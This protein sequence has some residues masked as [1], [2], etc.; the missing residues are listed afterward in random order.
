LLLDPNNGAGEYSEDG[1]A[2][3]LPLFDCPTAIFVLDRQL[4][5]STKMFDPRNYGN[6]VMARHRVA[7]IVLANPK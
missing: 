7:E 2:P 1:H 6:V 3:F 4:P 5:L